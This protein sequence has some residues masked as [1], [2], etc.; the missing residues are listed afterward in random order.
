MPYRRSPL[1]L[2][3]LLLIA[4]LSAPAGAA[5]PPQEAPGRAD[6]PTAATPAAPRSTPPAGAEA[7]PQ[8]RP[9]PAV[10][11]AAE[12][13]PPLPSHTVVIRPTPEISPPRPARPPETISL[14]LREADLVEVLRSFARL[15]GFNLVVDPAV[16]GTVTVELRDVRWELALAVILRTH[17]LAA[18]VDGRIVAIHPLPIAGR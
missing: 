8:G 9:A 17:G 11:P 4:L 18:E 7:P 10:P 3:A 2:A 13:T 12:I 15:G 14:S 16:K 6:A 5:A 1:P